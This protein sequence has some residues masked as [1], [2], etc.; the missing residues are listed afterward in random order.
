MRVLLKAYSWC[1]CH[2]QRIGTIAIGHTAKRVEEIL[3]DWLLY[4]M[5]VTICTTAWGPL[6]GSLAAFATMMPLSALVCTAYLRFYDWA[7]VDWFG[8]EAV[9]GFVQHSSS[10]SR[11]VRV[12]QAIASR[13]DVPAFFALSLYSDPFMV[14]IYLRRSTLKY[15]GLTKRDWI[16]FWTSVVFSNAYWTIR[17]TAI[18]EVVRAGYRLFEP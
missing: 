13:G 12:V 9:K 17:W 8:L 18:V 16:V 10:T 15:D 5:V 3:F 7:K 14:T 4:G 6:Y 11:F 2:K 1:A